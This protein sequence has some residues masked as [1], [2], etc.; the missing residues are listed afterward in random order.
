M[1]RFTPRIAP[2]PYFRRSSRAFTLIELLAVIAI[3]GV[4]ATLIIG[5]VSRVRDMARR[6]TCSSNLRQIGAA[7][8]LY[9]AEN[10]GLYPATRSPNYTAS[11]SG[12]TYPVPYTPT[13]P[14]PGAN[15]LLDGWQVEISRY[16]VRDQKYVWDV[17]DLTGQLNIAHC[18]AY[19]LFFDASKKLSAQSNISSAGYGMNV[20]L[21]INGAN[22]SANWA[23]VA[24]RFPAASLNNPART[25]LVGDSPEYFINVGGS[26]VASTAYPD[27]YSNGAPTR[28]GTSANYVYA[29]GHV[30][31]LSSR[32]ALTALPFKQ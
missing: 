9:A 21:N 17:K 18:P 23:G 5:T 19:D 10:R 28:H 11:P 27:G 7:Y 20:N 30:S 12:Q 14:P 24:V 3:V 26:W 2:S 13:N 8:Q 29:D 6:A 32:E 1:F 16:I 22:Y 15:P 31:S 25:I 4:L